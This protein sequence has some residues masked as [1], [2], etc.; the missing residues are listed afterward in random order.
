MSDVDLSG[1]LLDDMTARLRLLGK[2]AAAYLK[3]I[4][5]QQR[6]RK[7]KVSKM[8]VE[9]GVSKR[10]SVWVMK[11]APS[12]RPPYMRTGTLARHTGYLVNK[13]KKSVRLVVFSDAVT[14]DKPE[15]GGTKPYPLFQEIGAGF[16]G[17]HPHL[18]PTLKHME[19]NARTILG[20]PLSQTTVKRLAGMMRGAF[21]QEAR[22]I[23]K[24]G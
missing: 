22:T 9:K 13:R 23:I 21:P 3:R 19:Q 15:G 5:S 24:V 2:D 4:V 16:G 18:A 17:A 12:G 14:G 7:M 1:P 10:K 20:R 8:V 11:G 6:A